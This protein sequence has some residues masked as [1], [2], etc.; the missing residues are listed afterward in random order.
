MKGCFSDTL[1]S[2]S[3]FDCK[4]F[5]VHTQ[6]YSVQPHGRFIWQD[7]REGWKSK[8][9]EAQP[10]TV[11]SSEKKRKMISKPLCLSLQWESGSASSPFF[12][13]TPSADTAKLEDCSCVFTKA[14]YP[15]PSLIWGHSISTA[16]LWKQPS[17]WEGRERERKKNTSGQ[18]NWLVTQ[19]GVIIEINHPILFHNLT[20]PQLTFLWHLPSRLSYNMYSPEW[21]PDCQEDSL[22]PLVGLVWHCDL[23]EKISSNG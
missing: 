10:S 5:N 19:K 7:Q 13:V 8:G 14:S 2:Y 18:W 4:L 16:S 15:I 6:R 3:R 23:H 11:A 20:L 12:I 21:G 1:E 22:L 17:A 9:S